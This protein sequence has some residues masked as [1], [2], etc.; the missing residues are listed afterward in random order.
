MLHPV[1]IAVLCLYGD[2]VGRGEAKGSNQNIHSAEVVTS[3]PFWI[4]ATLQCHSPNFSPGRATVQ[5]VVRRGSLCV[6]YPLC[7]W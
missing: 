1:R 5:L 7:T 6:V 3:L 2:G 4:T